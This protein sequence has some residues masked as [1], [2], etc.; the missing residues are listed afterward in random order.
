MGDQRRLWAE[1]YAFWADED[2]RR[3]LIHARRSLE[4]GGLNTEIEASSGPKQTRDQPTTKSRPARV[5]GT[6]IGQGT[7]AAVD[8]VGVAS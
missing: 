1:L 3:S 7:T 8:S 4:E 5:T 2:W 6:P